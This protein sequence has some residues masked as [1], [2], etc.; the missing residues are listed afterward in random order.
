MVDGLEKRKLQRLEFPLEVTVE[1]VSVQ[2][3]PRGL[4][5]LHLKS[6][7]IS[8]GGICLE[9]K[10]IEIDG[11]NLLSGPPFARENRLQMSIE[12]I[13]KE[14]PFKAIGEV[15]WYDISRDIPEFIY[16]VGV[17]FIEIKNN[18]KDQLSRF[19]KFA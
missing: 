4:P 11:V 9:T 13:P 16:R 12:L 8:I 14:P 18:G 1:I 2:V 5:T 6:R 7:N 19:L 3:L 10:S 15:L 17:T